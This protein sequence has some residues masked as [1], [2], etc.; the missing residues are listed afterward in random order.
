MVLYDSHSVFFIAALRS[1][2]CVN[3]WIVVS[4][5]LCSDLKGAASPTSPKAG[6]SLARGA[7]ISTSS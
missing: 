6:K 7:F 4:G 2:W 1:S 5:R 3:R